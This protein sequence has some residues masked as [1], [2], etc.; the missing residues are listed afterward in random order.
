M[1]RTAAS[2]VPSGDQRAGPQAIA[3]ENSVSGAIVRGRDIDRHQPASIVV[4]LHGHDRPAVR[5][6]VR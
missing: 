5:V 3:V 4:V 1:K 2:R 6:N